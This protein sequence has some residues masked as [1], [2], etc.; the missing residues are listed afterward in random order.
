MTTPPVGL[1]DR[2]LETT[3]VAAAEK[4]TSD[5]LDEKYLLL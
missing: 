5:R 1:Y 3:K 4:C 2:W